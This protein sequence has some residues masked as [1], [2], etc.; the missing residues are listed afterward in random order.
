MDL[1]ARLQQWGA[2][3][4]VGDVLMKLCSELRVYSNYLSNYPSALAAIDRVRSALPF[5]PPLPLPFPLRSPLPIPL[6]SPLP[7]PPSGSFS[8]F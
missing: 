8:G 3:Q 6:R 5:P 4:C 7:F 2:E 1:Q